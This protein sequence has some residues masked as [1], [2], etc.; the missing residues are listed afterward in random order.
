[1]KHKAIKYELTNG[2]EIHLEWLYEKEL[3][4]LLH[5]PT[6][7]EEAVKIKLRNASL[8]KVVNK[9]IICS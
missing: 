7:I 1:M 3:N 2:R 5:I 9:I 6:T 4:A 8:L